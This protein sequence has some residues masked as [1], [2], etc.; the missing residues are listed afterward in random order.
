M[1]FITEKA[2][3]LQHAYHRIKRYCGDKILLIAGLKIMRSHRIVNYERKKC[4]GT[5]FHD[6]L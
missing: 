2:T 4:V 6:A 3:V 1:S 5:P